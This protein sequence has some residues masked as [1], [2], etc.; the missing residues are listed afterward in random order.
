M[1]EKWQEN[2]RKMVVKW[3]KNEIKRLGKLMEN[4]GNVKKLGIIKW[5]LEIKQQGI[6]WKLR[7]RGI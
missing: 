2:G 1:V 7:V 5:T 4:V 6:F 3:Q